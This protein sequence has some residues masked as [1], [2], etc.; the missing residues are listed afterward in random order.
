MEDHAL[1]QSWFEN[2][3]LDRDPMGGGGSGG[4][5][6][7]QG[8]DVDSMDSGIRLPG[9]KSKCSSPQL[10]ALKQVT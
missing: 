8:P 4:G 5:A 6:K 10:H 7:E 1:P 9:F 2:Q 3:A